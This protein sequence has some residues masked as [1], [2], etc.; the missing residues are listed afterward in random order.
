MWYHFYI[1]NLMQ[2][3]SVQMS[4]FAFPTLKELAAAT[5]EDLRNAGFGYR[6]AIFWLTILASSIVLEKT[7]GS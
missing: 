4:F 6:S 2:L 1:R 3:A 7:F 5:E